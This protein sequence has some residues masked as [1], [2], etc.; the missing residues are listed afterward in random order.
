MKLIAF[1]VRNYPKRAALAV[2]AS[3]VGG[4]SNAGLLTVLNRTLHNDGASR[5]GLLWFF[6]GLCTLVALSRLTTELLLTEVGQ[7]SLFDLRMKICEQIIATPLK[8]LEDY[9]G[10]RLLVILTDD[11]SMISATPASLSLLCINVAVVI[12]GLAYMAWLS[13]PVLL[14][15]LGLIAV[16]AITYQL[17]ILRAFRYFMLARQEADRLFGNYRALINGAKELKLHRRRREVFISQTLRDSTLALRR[18]F[19]VGTAIYSTATS[20]G[21]ILVFVIIALVLFVLPG[22]YRLEGN[23]MMGFTLT[24][25]FLM[26]PLQGILNTVPGLSRANIAMNK[27]SELCPSLAR[28]GNETEA[29]VPADTK[30]VIERL[31]LNGVTHSYY[32]EGEGETFTLGPLDLELV[33][34]ELLFIVGGNGSGKTTLAKLITGLYTSDTGEICLDG[35]LITDENRAFYR[36]HFAA[37]FSDFHLF[38]NLLGIEQPGLDEEARAYLSRFQLEHNVTIKDGG[39][40]TVKLS[41]GQRKRLA[42]LVAF[43]EDRPIYLFDE[44]AADQDPHFKNVFYLNLLPELKARGKAVIVISHDDRYYHIADRIVKLE[45][46]KIEKDFLQHDDLAL[47]TPNFTGA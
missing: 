8:R 43:L 18:H 42:L 14:V 37:V 26:T 22:V 36:E 20:W 5:A 4:A 44:W 19:F 6:I 13:V 45:S 30:L 33:G 2:F 47:L 11:V 27:V 46:G 1:L 10:H 32:R 16:G 9:G 35:Q 15:V 3:I 23:V 7:A 34:G 28:S 31:R 40:S 25:L 17:P 38:E 39:F 24:L 29:P 12:G 21:Q 41:Q